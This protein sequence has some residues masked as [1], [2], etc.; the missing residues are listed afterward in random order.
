MNRPGRR[1]ILLVIAGIVFIGLGAFVV[2][3]LFQ[4][5]LAPPALPT[6][7]PVAVE[8]VLV[9]SRGIPLGAVLAPNDLQL[10][11]IP[12]E[13]VPL[14]RMSNINDAVGK[15][16]NIPMVA[17]EM[18]L[19]HHLVDPSN[20]IDRTLAF[21]L[22]DDQVLMAF[23]IVDLMSSLNILKKGDVVD[24]FV[25]KE[26]AAGGLLG[27]EEQTELYT[28]DAFQRITITAIVMNVV[29]DRQPVPTQGLEPEAILTP[30]AAPTPT[31]LP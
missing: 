5:V 30:G 22:E 26:H 10:V 16:V 15:V 13:M 17:G 24:I 29:T 23:P 7:Q 18:V 28:Y 25:S 11:Q 8:N 2:W 1:G 14:N 12:V 9:T 20:I 31:P 27:G 3:R 19:P 21:S 6:P 4:A